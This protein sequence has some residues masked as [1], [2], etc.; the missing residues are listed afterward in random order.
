M[1]DKYDNSKSFKLSNRN[2]E[3]INYLVND[4]HFKSDSEAVRFCI[5]LVV[6]LSRKNL[7]TES[8]AK[9]FEDIGEWH[10][11]DY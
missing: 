5:D 11:I 3:K 7:L 6:A 1:N 8:T 9:L 10:E 2:I 4:K